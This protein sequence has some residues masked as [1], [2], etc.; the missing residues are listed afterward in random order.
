MISTE[1]EKLTKSKTAI[2]KSIQ[3]KRTGLTLAEIYAEYNNYIKNMSDVRN[4]DECGL[5]DYAEDRCFYLELNVESIRPYAF[6]EY[7]CLQA[8]YLTH[9]EVVKISK[10]SFYSVEPIIYVPSNLLAEYQNTPI[11]SDMDIRAYESL[12]Q[13]EMYLLQHIE[14]QPISWVE[15]KTIKEINNEFRI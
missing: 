4:P 9:S 10:D 2:R 6:R 12:T 11:W 14:V 3:R 1:L 15:G 13:D 5:K 8:L 7:T